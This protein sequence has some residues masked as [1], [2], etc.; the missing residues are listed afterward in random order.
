MKKVKILR[1]KSYAEILSEL[2]DNP[3]MPGDNMDF[4]NSKICEDGPTTSSYK[5]GAKRQVPRLRTKAS[6]PQSPLKK[7]TKFQAEGI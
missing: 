1:K 2:V 3:Q 4:D 5:P 7:K 6:V